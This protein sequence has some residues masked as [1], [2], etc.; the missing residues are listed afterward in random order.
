MYPVTQSN[1]SFIKK[2]KMTFDNGFSDPEYTLYTE[3]NTGIEYFALV[4]VLGNIF[5][6]IPTLPEMDNLFTLPIYRSDNKITTI[7]F[8]TCC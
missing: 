5:A 1:T 7:V 3:D 2:I 6:R 4:T 8:P